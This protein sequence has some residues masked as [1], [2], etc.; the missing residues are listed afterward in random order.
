MRRVNRVAEILQ[1]QKQSALRPF[2]HSR[3]SMQ[4]VNA[5]SQADHRGQKSGSCPRIAHKQIER[6]LR[7]ATPRDAPAQPVNRQRAIAGLEGIRGDIDHESELLQTL[8]HDLGVLAPERAFQDGFAIGQRG[9]HQRPIGDAFG[10]GHREVRPDGLMQR[11]DF[12]D[13]GERHG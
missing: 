3:D 12:D 4:P 11:Q 7:R 1:G 6:L 5:L 2:M 9:Q 8:H 10:T 13:V